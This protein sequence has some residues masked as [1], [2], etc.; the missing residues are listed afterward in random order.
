VA[1]GVRR[2]TGASD[3]VMG[4]PSMPRAPVMQLTPTR[5]P[6][7]AASTGSARR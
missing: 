4:A 2:R 1:R 6:A 3:V 5:R 7:P